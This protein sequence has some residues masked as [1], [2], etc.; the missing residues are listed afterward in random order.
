[1]M[2]IVGINYMNKI[3]H[4]PIT[5]TPE[6]YYVKKYLTHTFKIYII[7]AF[8]INSCANVV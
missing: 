6:L 2:V 7:I 4:Y 8:I 1:M 3:H 5:S